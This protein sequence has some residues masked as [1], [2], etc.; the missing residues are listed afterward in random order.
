MRELGQ[1]RAVEEKETGRGRRGEREGWGGR[2]EKAPGGLGRRGVGD[3]R[4]S[5]TE[6]LYRLVSFIEEN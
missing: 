5:M 4:A 1:I 2:N 3:D 6:G